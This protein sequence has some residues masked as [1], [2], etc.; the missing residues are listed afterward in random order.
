MTRTHSSRKT[1]LHR[2]DDEKALFAGAGR[3]AEDVFVG[4]MG[5][6]SFQLFTNLPRLR[7]E[8][9]R[10]IYGV[11]ELARQQAGAASGEGRRSV[12]SASEVSEVEAAERE[13]KLRL[14]LKSARRR[15][16]RLTQTLKQRETRLAAL[17]G[18][19]S[20]T[21]APESRSKPSRPA[22]MS[23]VETP[24]PASR[25]RNPKTPSTDQE[26]R[27]DRY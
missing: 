22:Q 23:M 2:L 7:P 9:L 13:Q 14:A 15:V 4:L 3:S 25:P 19:D 8:Q 10:A 17:E 18:E 24:V 11:A 1:L 6:E 27:S 26:T 12:P 21:E 16:R 5:Y 20:E